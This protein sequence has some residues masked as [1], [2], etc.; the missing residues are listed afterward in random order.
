MAMV[1]YNMAIRAALVTL[2]TFE[3]LFVKGYSQ[4]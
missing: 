1:T 4:S 3:S 2:K